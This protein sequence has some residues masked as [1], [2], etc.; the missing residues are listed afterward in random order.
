MDDADTPCLNDDV[1]I[2]GVIYSTDDDCI[3]ILFRCDGGRQG[4]VCIPLAEFFSRAV[5]ARPERE[6]TL[7]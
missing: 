1:E 3:I 2:K 6:V 4:R 5:D 7:Q